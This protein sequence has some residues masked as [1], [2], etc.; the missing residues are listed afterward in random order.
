MDRSACTR[1]AFVVIGAWF[2]L[3]SV[4]ELPVVIQ[5]VR[6]DAGERHWLVLY[7]MLPLLGAL[8]IRWSRDL[9]RWTTGPATAPSE[10]SAP[11]RLEDLQATGIGL[12]GLLS[13][14][15]NLPLA[16]TRVHEVPSRWAA[17][18]VEEGD[19]WPHGEGWWLQ[20]WIASALSVAIGLGLLLGARAVARWW[21]AKP[22][23][24]QLRPLEPVS[25]RLS[26]SAPLRPRADRADALAAAL[27]VLGI[28]L[29]AQALPVVLATAS[30][31]DLRSPLE[32]TLDEPPPSRFGP[33][34]YVAVLRLIVGLALFVGARGLSKLWRRLRS[35]ASAVP[36]ASGA[37][38]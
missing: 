3:E 33:L 11:L 35:G 2:L 8:V 29:V 15:Q 9:A 26:T 22:R 27:A 6:G 12:V 32:W 19:L 5:I 20:D 37:E 10:S 24:R 21:G 31:T 17:R 23:G 16:L 38:P 7:A 4:G 36:R 1:I 13:V 25:H 18:A 30:L 14:V 34:E 28:F